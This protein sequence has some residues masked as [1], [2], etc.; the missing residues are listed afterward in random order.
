[1]AQE[2]ANVQHNEHL[3]LS[4]EIGGH[5]IEIPFMSSFIGFGIE[6]ALILGL[7]FVYRACKNSSLVVLFES[8]YEKVFLFF[9]DILWKEEK[10][11]IKKYVTTL[12]FIIL[13]ANLIGFMIEFVAPV[14]GLNESK[15]FI[16]EHYLTSL[17]TDI[18]F[19][20]AM[21]V[22]SVFIVLFVQL[23][24]L[25]TLH[26]IYDFFPIFGKGYLKYER[27]QK[28]AIVDWLIYIP[29]KIFD[30]VISVFLGLLEIIWTLA[31][32][33]SLSFRLFGNMTSGW[34]LLGMLYAAL[35][36]LTIWLTWA[37]W[38]FEF[39]VLFPLI[40]FA[41]ELLVALIQALVFPLLIA[42]FIKVAKSA[43]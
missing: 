16:L 7:V 35:G 10:S 17:T 29:V 1:M 21:A 4:T 42:I 22:V 20:V 14:F 23:R 12:F 15:H 38:G 31:K 37:F 36:G 2:S 40:I 6:L 13:S 33:I 27:G 9:E 3:L 28:S 11:W 39:P 30:I 8:I 34:V 24:H 26:F 5:E 18:N 25:W 41:Q 43:E 32:V 19:N